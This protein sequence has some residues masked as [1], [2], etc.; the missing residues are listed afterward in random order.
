MNITQAIDDIC[1]VKLL[2]LGYKR[3]ND[4][5]IEAR[6]A[7]NF[8]YRIA[9]RDGL[10]LYTNK[11]KIPKHRAFAADDFVVTH[12]ATQKLVTV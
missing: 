8:E 7:A 5:D 10:V 6:V 9:H 4:P 1:R 3:Y 12:N 11:I 2:R